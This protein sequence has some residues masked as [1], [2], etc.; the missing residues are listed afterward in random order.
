MSDNVLIK[1]FVL[2]K[3]LFGIALKNRAFIYRKRPKIAF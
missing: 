3:N 2:F 1:Y